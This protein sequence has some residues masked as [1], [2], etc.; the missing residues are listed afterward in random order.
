M[1]FPRMN[2]KNTVID[3]ASPSRIDVCAKY[4]K[5]ISHKRNNFTTAEMFDWIKDNYTYFSYSI[6]G[7]T[8]ILRIKKDILGIR[9]YKILPENK[10][11]YQRGNILWKIE[12]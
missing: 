9:I 12:N 4:I 5:H 1:L 7:L 6:R 3:M 8:A 2:G 10:N 11:L